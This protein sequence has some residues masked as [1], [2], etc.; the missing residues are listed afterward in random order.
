VY[1]L[2][3]SPKNRDDIY[4]AIEGK[5]IW[6]EQSGFFTPDEFLQHCQSAAG[7]HLQVLI[8]DMD[9]TDPSALIKGLRFYRASRK[10]TRIV[11]VA[12]GRQ[13]GDP[14]VT[15]LLPLQIWDIVAPDPEDQSGTADGEEDAEDEEMP[16]Y[17]TLLLKQQLAMELDYGNVARWDVGLNPVQQ[18]PT[19]AKRK[20]KERSQPSQPQFDPAII[21][22]L[23]TLSVEPPPPR[24]KI[25][26]SQFDPAI[27]EHLHTIAVEPPPPRVDVRY[28]KQI[29]GTFVIAVGSPDRRGGSTSA[30]LQIT[31]AL[32]QQGHKAA[33]FEANDPDMS[34]GA[35]EF[36]LEGESIHAVGGSRFQDIDLFQVGPDH[37]LFHAAYP[38]YNYV[39]LDMGQLIKNKEPSKH[40]DYFLKANL[41]IVTTGPTLAEFDR[42][43]KLLGLLHEQGVVSPMQV[44]VNYA[45][46]ESF[47]AFERYFSK[48]EQKQLELTFH[49]NGFIPDYYKI[50]APA[51]KMLHEFIKKYVHTQK[52]KSWQFWR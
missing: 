4:E 20:S 15:M 31:K 37:K 30:A 45:D 27:I 16:S 28:E 25:K 51:K 52:K 19:P 23:H 50:S 32:C 38:H 17:L 21:E 48:E 35:F 41:R 6:Y 40:F 3:V 10:S 7:V 9:C 44:L 39:I 43:T 29:V 2:L 36:L 18:S 24:E 47:S 26:P 49:L 12:S 22:H 11:L 33:C 42:L 8:V 14:T 13:P 1:G 34:P 46:E 5:E